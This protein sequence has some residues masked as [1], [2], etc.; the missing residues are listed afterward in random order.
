MVTNTSHSLNLLNNYFS[1]NEFDFINNANSENKKLD[2]IIDQEIKYKDTL[3]NI[4]NYLNGKNMFELLSK[5]QSILNDVN[6]NIRLLEDLKDISSKIGIDIINLLVNVE[7]NPDEKEKFSSQIQELKDLINTFM[8]TNKNVESKVSLNNKTIEDFFS[9]SVIKDFLSSINYNANEVNNNNQNSSI[10]RDSG[11]I[12]DNPVLVI[13][14]KLKKVF[15]PYY[16]REIDLYLEQYPNSYKSAKDVI[17]KEFVLPLDHYMHHPVVARFRETY[18]LIRDRES[19]SIIDALKYALDIMFH[20]ELNPAIIA[21]C[22]TQEQLEH[23]M[24]CAEKNRLDEFKDFEIR[25]EVAPL[26]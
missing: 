2:A 9:V 5:A 15:L 10:V 11:Q 25:F 22:K 3:G 17:N 24:D 16:K 19:K 6:T 18:A 13:S 4:I 8:K 26:A 7:E 20:Y 14:E 21:A 12:N 23:Y 1:E